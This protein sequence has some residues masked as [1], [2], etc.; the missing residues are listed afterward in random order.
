MKKPGKIKVLLRMLRLVRPLTG[1][2]LLA[3]VMGTLGF[4]CAQFIPILGG[5]AVL[6]GLKI[7]I[8]FSIR[9]LQI[10]LIGTRKCCSY[11]KNRTATTCIRRR[12]T[13]RAGCGGIR[14]RFAFSCFCCFT[15]LRSYVAARRRK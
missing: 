11:G 1:F 14:R 6:Y 5:Y 7:G 15:G 13:R 4:L 12:K 3:I 2:M 9:S 10:V 8:P